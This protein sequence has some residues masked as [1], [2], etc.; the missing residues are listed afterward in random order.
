MG[1]RVFDEDTTEI[2]VR[3]GETFILELEGQPGAGYEWR[4]EFDDAVDIEEL[5]ATGSAGGIGGASRQRFR[6]NP[7]HPGVRSIHLEY[8]RPWETKPEDRKTV[9]LRVIEDGEQ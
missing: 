2:S 3:P 6:L 5:D 7:R 9:T 1:E 8:G 4:I